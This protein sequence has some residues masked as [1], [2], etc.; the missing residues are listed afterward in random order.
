MK[1]ILASL[2]LFVFFAQN[3]FAQAQAI[4]PKSI[5]ISFIIN[6]FV[7][8]QRIRT[9]SLSAI[10]RDKRIA[11]FKQ[12]SPG[13]ALTYY[14]GLSP[15]IDF[16]GTLGGSSVNLPLAGNTFTKQYLL[17]EADASANFKMVA[18]NAKANAY[19][20]AGVGASKYKNIFGAFIPLGGGIKANLFSGSQAFVQ[21]QY[22]VPV[23]PDA[24]NYHFQVSIGVSGIVSKKRA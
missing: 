10:I 16:A 24:N 9:S 14:K 1:K 19:L 21:F 13:V 3:S 4:R 23:T 7:T 15:H 20:I 18:E 6:D 22:R 5:G 17:L 12:M 2:V 8:A 11:K